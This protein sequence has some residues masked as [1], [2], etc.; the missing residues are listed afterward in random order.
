MLPDMHVSQTVMTKWGRK[1]QNKFVPVFF[2]NQLISGHLQGAGSSVWKLTGAPSHHGG[3][4]PCC[5]R[6]P[7]QTRR[8]EGLQ[9]SKEMTD[10]QES[11]GACYTE[12]LLHMESLCW[13]AEG[14]FL[15]SCGFVQ[16]CPSLLPSKSCSTG[17]PLSPYL[18]S[19]ISETTKQSSAI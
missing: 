13:W 16:A 19:W 7:I 17:Q 6:S 11:R 2:L 4:A 1:G 18:Y 8:V 5:S 3:M 14:V 12:Q 9:S 15:F 10:Q